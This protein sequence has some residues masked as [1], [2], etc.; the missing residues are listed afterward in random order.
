MIP[1]EHWKNLYYA[2]CFKYFTN[3]LLGSKKFSKASLEHEESRLIIPFFDENKNLFGFS[4]RSLESNAFLRYINIV[5]DDS[6][7]ENIWY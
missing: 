1:E 6:K 4:G 2:E 7:K 3:S 5:L